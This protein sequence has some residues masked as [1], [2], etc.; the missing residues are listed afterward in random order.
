MKIKKKRLNPII[1]T[2]VSLLLIGS[3]VS[4]GTNS[5]DEISTSISS[6]EVTTEI[7]TTA[8]EATT[9]T[10]TTK[11]TTK[12]TTKK[13]TTKPTTTKTTTKPTTTETTTKPNTTETATETTTETTT[14]I[15]TTEKPLEI[16]ECPDLSGINYDEAVKMY[17]A[18][19]TI[20]KDSE[21][22]NSY[23]SAGSIIEQDV[24]FPSKVEK[25]TVVKV[26]VSL[27]PVAVQT[28]PPQA[29]QPAQSATVHFILNTDTNCI[30]IKDTCRAAT[31]ILPEN[32]S[33]VDIA[34]SDLSNY[35]G[36]YWA[37]GICS[38]KYS[39]MLPKFDK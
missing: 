20:R 34:E 35:N 4:C 30:H 14:K 33:T 36:M 18:Y 22:H 15:T 8:S 32:Y 26:K 11:T 9:K 39:D 13:T 21:E 27:G 24:K 7:K 17:S 5:E 31:Q 38:K 12:A 25:G 29:V 3:C 1:T 37:C 19:I 28:T 2:V 6:S 16:V 10:T 23:I